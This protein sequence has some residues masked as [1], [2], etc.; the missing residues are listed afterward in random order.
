MFLGPD[1]SGVMLEVMAVQ[2]D[3]A[4]VI[5]HAIPVRNRYRKYL[6][7]DLNDQEGDGDA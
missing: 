4:L 5:I 7:P 3:E 6:E 2:T 1:E